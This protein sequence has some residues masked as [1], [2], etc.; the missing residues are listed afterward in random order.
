MSHW[1]P[2]SMTML[3]LA[4]VV[5][6]AMAAEPV[7]PAAPADAL[8][9]R[10]G[11]L[12]VVAPPGT[13]VR[14]EQL[15]HAF[16]F[17]TAISRHAFNGRMDPADRN[18]YLKTLRD[19][20]NFAVHEN[21]LKWDF[22]QSGPNDASF[23]MPDAML[24]WAQA[25]GLAMRG[26][27]IMWAKPWRVPDWVKPL[28]DDE[29]RVT[30]KQRVKGVASHYRGRLRGLDINNEMLDGD[31]VQGRLGDDARAQLFRWAHAADP[32]QRLFVN[33]ND[34]LTG[35]RLEVYAD[36]IQ[37]LLDRGA[38]VGGIGLQGHLEG[39]ADPD[40]IRAALDRLAAFDLPIWITEF[41]VLTDDE[42]VKAQALQTTYR[43]AFEHP[44]VEGIL[45]WGFWGGRH[46]LN[47]KNAIPGYTALWS[48]DW[49]A[50]PSAT[51]YRKLVF[52]TWWSRASDPADD[53][54]HASFDVFAGSHRVTVGDHSV[55][56]DLAPGQEHE[57]RVSNSLRATR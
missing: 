27:T 5:P 16:P 14:V 4:T 42:A 23:A 13:M 31:F 1:L 44:A 25:N 51:A 3:A 38:P 50:T 15:R 18:L 6:W 2:F 49:H 29:L 53:T 20:F 17:G 10:K 37:G 43:L 26:H 34:V 36:L 21:A 22:T 12:I 9:H 7:D 8:A 28:T 46:W 48:E 19:H 24:A 54:G 47:S 35:G 57:V 30:L 56:V 11:R 40:V 52:G 41:D 45:M 33:E 39:P 32:D 55:E